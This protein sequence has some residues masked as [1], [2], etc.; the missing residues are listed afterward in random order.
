MVAQYAE[1]GTNKAGLGVG[2]AALYIFLVFFSLGMDAASWVV[3][4]E[5]FP[6][7]IRAKGYAVAV[8]A[9][10]LINL[11]YLQVTPQAFANLGW[12]YFMVRIPLAVD[13]SAWLHLMRYDVPGLCQHFCSRFRLT[14]LGCPGNERDS[15]R[16]NCRSLW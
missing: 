2:V 3:L 8:S 11:V 12:K 7:F 15:A 14:V 1:A 10:S 16:R 4:S 6:N 5:I 9:K 13:P